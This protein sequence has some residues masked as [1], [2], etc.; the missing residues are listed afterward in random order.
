MLITSFGLFRNATAENSIA[1]LKSGIFEYGKPKSVMTDHGST[2]YANRKEAK[3]EN[4]QLRI[5]LNALE[6]KHCVARVNRP[7][8]NGKVERF[9]LSYK[10][11]YATAVLR[12]S[13][14]ISNTITK[15]DYI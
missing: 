4:T 8:T 12:I 2:Y 10:T 7:Q 3:Q 6:I 9:F 11:E 1:L 5:V 14:I 15:K 13:E